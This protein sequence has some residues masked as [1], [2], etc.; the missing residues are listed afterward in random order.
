[1]RYE[2][3]EELDSIKEV[4][5]ESSIRS[6]IGSKSITPHRF[7]VAFKS[8]L[9]SCFKTPQ[10]KLNSSPLTKLA[11]E[12]ISRSEFHNSSPSNKSSLKRVFK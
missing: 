12:W 9:K 11:R 6:I 1:M 2:N 4:E 5:E 7:Q 3:K 10:N 8:G